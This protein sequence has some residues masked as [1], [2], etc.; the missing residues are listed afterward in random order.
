MSELISL[1]NYPIPLHVIRLLYR[2]MIM[3]VWRH[4]LLLTAP[5]WLVC[6]INVDIIMGWTTLYLCIIDLDVKNLISK[7]EKYGSECGKF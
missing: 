6:E 4:L 2:A 5:K 3:V 1:E 7:G